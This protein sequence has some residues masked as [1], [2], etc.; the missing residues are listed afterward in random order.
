MLDLLKPLAR[1]NLFT[2]NKLSHRVERSGGEMTP[3]RL[4]SK[5]IGGK[6]TDEMGEG[7]RNFRS[8]RIT[9]FRIFPFRTRK[10]LIGHPVLRELTPHMG[11]IS[12]EM[13]VTSVV[14]AVDVGTGTA[15]VLAPGSPLQPVFFRV[16][17]NRTAVSEGQGLLKRNID[18]LSDSV[19]SGV[20]DTSK[21]QGRRHTRRDLVGQVTGR[22]TL[23]LGIIA[24]AI[25]KAASSIGDCVA[26]F[27]VSMGSR[28]SERGQRNS[29]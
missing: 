10:Y 9:V 19:Q 29:H 25:E 13:D 6:L 17:R 20:T 22:R 8:V 1:P 18:A 24:L 26:A 2:F 7:L 12:G 23:S 14:A 3:L 11:H 27:V 4:L 15:I 28:A 16:A 21:S 5:F